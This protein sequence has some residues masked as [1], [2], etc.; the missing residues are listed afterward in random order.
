MGTKQAWTRWSQRGQTFHL[1]Q[2][3]VLKKLH[4]GNAGITIRNNSEIGIW[5][6]TSETT[7]YKWGRWSSY[8]GRGCPS[9]LSNTPEGCG[10]LP[11]MWHTIY[12]NI[13]QNL[14]SRAQIWTHL[15][16]LPLHILRFQISR[17]SSDNSCIPNSPFI[18][19]ESLQICNNH[20]WP[21]TALKGYYLL[22][23]LLGD[24]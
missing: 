18:G 16:I 3:Y 23:M 15:L 14:E 19:V 6:L 5:F 9:F 10:V 8:Q 12:E 1:L 20:L 11:V 17:M 2:K 24:L 4:S 21:G 22:S 13:C 7:L